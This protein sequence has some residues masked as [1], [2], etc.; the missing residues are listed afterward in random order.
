MDDVFPKFIIETDDDLG[1]CLILSKV[2]YHRQIAVDFNKVK[3]GGWFKFNPVN[4]SFTFFG[5]SEQF[6][7]AEFNL[8]KECV[9]RDRVFD[10]P[11]LCRPLSKYLFYYETQSGELIPLNDEKSKVV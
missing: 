9:D 5:K 2:T 11:H 8:I 4:N 3:G 10:G 7:E 6:G 1:D